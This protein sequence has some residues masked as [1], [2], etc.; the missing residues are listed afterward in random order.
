M[1]WDER[2]ALRAQGIDPDSLREQ[3][4]VALVRYLMWANG[5]PLPDLRRPRHRRRR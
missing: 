4:R 5:L 2:E 1:D 3:L